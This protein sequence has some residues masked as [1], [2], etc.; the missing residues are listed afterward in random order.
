[1]S[2]A[3]IKVPFAYHAILFV[4]IAEYWKTATVTESSYFSQCVIVNIFGHCH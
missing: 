3:H 4:V 2:Q 1:M